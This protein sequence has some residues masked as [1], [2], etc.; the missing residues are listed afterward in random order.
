MRRS[1]VLVLSLIQLCTQYIQAQS[2]E[3]HILS[4]NL[5]SSSHGYTEL[6]GQMIVPPL[7]RAGTYYLW[8]GL[9]PT[10]NAGVFQDVLDGRS[11]NWHFAPGW[12]SP[13]YCTLS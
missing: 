10:D 5:P 8:P 2:V 13:S 4:Y 7:P 9:Q 3:W 11:G 12:Y 6:S 1:Y